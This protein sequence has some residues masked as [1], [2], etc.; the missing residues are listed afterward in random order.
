MKYFVAICVI[1][2]LALPALADAVRVGDLEID[3]VWTRVILRSGAPAGVFLRITNPGA[4]ADRLIGVSSPL[5]KIG[6]IHKSSMSNGLMKM[7]HV[8]HLDIPAG[9]QA[10]FKPGG[11]HI[12]LM[13]VTKSIKPGD[14]VPLTLTF[15]RAGKVEV[16]AKVHAMGDMP[17]MKPSI[18]P[19]TVYN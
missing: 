15:E 7:R 14:L 17:K 18:K 5:A 3:H 6:E 9:G 2:G 16:Q 11:Y 8:G 19:G 4:A 13:G 1:L 10:M 12:M